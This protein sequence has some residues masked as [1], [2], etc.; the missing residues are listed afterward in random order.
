MLVEE[1]LG[2]L[3]ITQRELAEAI[4]VPY[5]RVNELV[6]GKRGVTP[7]T[8][9]RLARFFGTSPDFWLSL[10]IRCDLYRVRQKERAEINSQRIAPFSCLVG[11]RLLI[12]SGEPAFRMTADR[13]YKLGEDAELAGYFLNSSVKRVSLGSFNMDTGEAIDSVPLGYFHTGL[14]SFDVAGDWMVFQSERVPTDRSEA[15]LASSNKEVMPVVAVDD[16]AIADGRPGPVTRRV[17][18]IFRDYTDRY[19]RQG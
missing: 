6:N 11:D 14:S 4:H 15:F 5:Q 1:F 9:L 2:P 12:P 3:G 7:S 10:Q 8:A 16:Q 18:S 13:M 17:M 19:G